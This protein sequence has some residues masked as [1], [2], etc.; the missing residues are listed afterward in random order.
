M[1]A[2]ICINSLVM[3]QSLRSAMCNTVYT[4]VIQ[5][6]K[7]ATCIPMIQVVR[8]FNNGYFDADKWLLISHKVLHT[9]TCTQ[10]C[11]YMY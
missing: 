1:W 6:A 7:S 3:A 4:H 11:V 2:S 8:T 10:V 9:C 5:N